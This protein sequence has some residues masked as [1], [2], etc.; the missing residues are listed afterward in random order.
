MV[1][2]KSCPSE[3][4]HLINLMPYKCNSFCITIDGCNVYWIWYVTWRPFM[5]R[6]FLQCPIKWYNILCFITN[7]NIDIK[8]CKT[9]D[10]S[11]YKLRDQI[12]LSCRAWRIKKI[13]PWGKLGHRFLAVLWDVA[14]CNWRNGP[15]LR[16]IMLIAYHPSRQRQQ[17]PRL[18]WSVLNWT[19]SHPKIS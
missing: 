8:T 14:C 9:S 15:T 12:Q 7:K 1:E 2:N 4:W 11:W 16:A 17:I 18:S 13:F 5:W 19:V 6:L 10:G 3:T